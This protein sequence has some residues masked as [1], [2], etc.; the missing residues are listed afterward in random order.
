MVDDDRAGLDLEALGLEDG[1]C[2]KSKGVGS[3]TQGD[4]HTIA[5]LHTPEERTT[6]GSAKVGDCWSEA[7]AI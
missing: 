1:G 7:R 2:G 4:E 6:D 5:L 3:A